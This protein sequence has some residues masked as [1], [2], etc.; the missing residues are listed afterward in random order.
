MPFAVFAVNAVFAGH[1]VAVNAAAKGEDIA[2]FGAEDDVVLIDGAFEAAGLVGAFE[3][4]GELVAV[5]F[6]L[7]VFGGRFV[8]VDVFGV[9][10]PFAFDVVGR[11]FGGRLLSEGEMADGEK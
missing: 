9:D 2:G 8:V 7:D 11:W 5:L 1:F 6:E 3:V 10:G 4:A